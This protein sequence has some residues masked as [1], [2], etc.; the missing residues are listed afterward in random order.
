MRLKLA[1]FYLSLQILTPTSVVTGNV[2]TSLFS[3][4]S[5]D[6]Q[7]APLTIDEPSSITIDNE[8]QRNLQVDETCDGVSGSFS[9]TDVTG[10]CTYAKLLEEYTRQVFDETGNT[11]ATGSSV[12]AKEDLDSKLMAAL[13]EAKSGEEAG[14]L[15]CKMMYDTNEQT[16]VPIYYVLFCT[17]V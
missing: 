7:D 9:I 2:I 14:D 16:W 15:I 6:G 8:Q 17:Y 12:S 10:Q 3:R 5:S 11:C 13:P 4:P 1:T